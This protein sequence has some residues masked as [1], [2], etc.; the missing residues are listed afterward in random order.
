MP[1]SLPVSS[2]SSI[3]QCKSQIV[4][5]VRS[6]SASTASKREKL[7]IKAFDIRPV[8]PEFSWNLPEPRQSEPHPARVI[9]GTLPPPRNIFHRRARGKATPEFL[10]NATPEPKRERAAPDEF[11]AWKRRIAEQ[12]RT[13]LRESVAALDKRRQTTLTNA[14]AMGKVRRKDRDERLN[15]PQ[16]E[17]ERLTDPTIMAANQILQRGP[18]P[19]PNREARLEQMAANVGAK[20]DAKKEARRN[21]LH[22]LYMNARSF[23]TT[24][25]QLNNEV[26]KIFVDQPF[27]DNNDNDNPWVVWGPPPSTGELLGA[28]R[29]GGRGGTSS[30]VNQALITGRRVKKIAEE[31]TGGKMN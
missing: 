8:R 18:L 19:D 26:D 31:L 13:S 20:E 1:P 15:A 5:A 7:H 28:S 24:E 6:F 17:D 3:R 29:S 11:V 4:V 10:A 9:K 21:A 22:T 12:R 14:R 25:E 27:A 16:R 23:I 30:S 2:L